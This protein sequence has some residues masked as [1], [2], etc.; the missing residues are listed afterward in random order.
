MK[1]FVE[2]LLDRLIARTYTE[3]DLDYVCNYLRKQIIRRKET[4]F[5]QKEAYD[6]LNGPKTINFDEHDLYIKQRY[7]LTL[8][9][10][11]D[12]VVLKSDLCFIA[13]FHNGIVYIAKDVPDAELSQLN[14]RHIKEFRNMLLSTPIKFIEI[15]SFGKV[16]QR[17][18]SY[19]NVISKN[20]GSNSPIPFWSIKTF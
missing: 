7:K 9:I 20:Y 5:R 3:S 6:L 11:K 10:A 18:E 19:T 14:R 4:Y 8:Y 13:T 17:L 1:P 16:K 15:E 12:L 2:E